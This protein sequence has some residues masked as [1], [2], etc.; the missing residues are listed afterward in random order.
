MH[1]VADEVINLMSDAFPELAERRELIAQVTQGEESRFRETLRRGMK[2]LDERFDEI[3]QTGMKELHPE[4]VADLYTTYGFPLDLTEVIAGEQDVRVN[5]HAASAIVRGAEEADGPIDPTAALDPSYRE[6]AQLAESTT[7][8]GYTTE[9]GDSEIVAIIRVVTSDG[10]EERTIVDQA[11]QGD[12]VEIAVKE[13]PFYAEAGGQVGDQ[14]DIHR[15]GSRARVRG[16]HRPIGTVSLHRATLEEGALRVG[17]RVTMDVDHDLRTA[18]RRN[19]SATHLLHWALK[20]VLG[21][22]AMQ[23]GSLVGPDVLRFDFAHNQPLSAD[24]IASVERLVND[25]ILTNAPVQTEVLAIDEARARG[26]VAIFEEKYGDVVR[27]LTMT[28]DSVELCGGTHAEALG[29]IGLFKIMSEGGTAAGVRRIFAATGIHAL[30]FVRGVQE[31]LT[32]ARVAAKA[33]TG[34]DLADKIAKI[35]QSEKQAH[36]RVKELEKQ[37]VEGGGSGGG[38]DSMLS[39]AKSV[40][41]VMVLGVKVAD[42][43]NM[44]T[45]RE[46]SE[47]LRDKLGDRAV[48]LAAAKTGDKAQL[49]LT[50]SKPA[51]DALKAGAL[52]KAIAKHVGGS[53]GGRPD[54]A[55]AGGT[56]T[57]GID[58]AVTAV[59][60]EVEKALGA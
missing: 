18:T 2:I 51:T 10:V 9:S 14:G 46:L 44:G 59:Y 60:G 35:V 38:I 28:Q 20:K 41:D 52:I 3:Q 23:K 29:D 43:T 53:G 1:E 36:K 11:A 6:V 19:H 50:V 49:A 40:G 17:D 5:I 37:L 31:E 22:H 33:T 4:V 47:K 58:D 26:A 55:Q 39:Q 56:E 32:R 8:N 16:T 12:D 48:V 25:K 30:D 45:L 13:T 15:E 54:M 27:V 24:E 21:Q 7:F 42:G 34:G 57:A